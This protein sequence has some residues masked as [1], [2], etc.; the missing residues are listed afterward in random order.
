MG[1]KAGRRGRSEPSH[2][3][4]AAGERCDLRERS[5]T[6]ASGRERLRIPHRQLMEQT[7]SSCCVSSGHRTHRP[8]LVLSE[9]MT[10]PSSTQTYEQ[11]IRVKQIKIPAV[12]MRGGTSNAIVF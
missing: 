6:F 11:E 4:H 5:S 7:G 12:F 10:L 9:L 1:R 8:A 3:D 2:P